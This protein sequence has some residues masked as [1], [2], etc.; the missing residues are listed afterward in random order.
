[1]AVAVMAAMAA[2]FGGGD[3]GGGGDGDDPPNRAPTVSASCDPCRVGP[4]GE[5]R[6]TAQA[7]D[8]DGDSLT[9]AWSAPRG[10]ITGPAD[11]AEAHWR[12]PADTGRVA[13]R[14][15]VSDGRDGTASATVS[16]EVVNAPPEF[17]EP[18]Y[19]FVLRE[20]EAG[21]DRPVALG[22]AVAEDPDG[23]E[24]TYALASGAGDLFA[25]GSGDGTV[26]YLGPGED[27][28]TEPNRYELT[29]RARDVHGA[30]ALAPVFVD[31]VNV[32]EPPVAAADTA[33]TAEDAGVLI[34]VL[35][36]DTDA[37]G[38][39]LRIEAITSPANGTARIAAD[40]GVAYAPEHD[41]HG[42]DRFVYTVA[43]GNGGT[44]EAAV[45]VEVAPVNDAPVAAADTARTA[46]DAEVLIDVLANDTDI[47]GDALRIE[48]ITSPSN[49]TARIAADGG[50]AYAPEHDWHGTDR[51]AYTVADGNGGRAE[52]EVTVEVA[53]VND[54]P[55]AVA[56]TART[57][58]DAEVLI[59]VLAN[60]TDAE[61]DALRIEAITSPANGTARIAASGG[62]EYTPESDWHGTDR[63]A[64]T[65]ADGNG[66]RAEAEVTVKVAPVNDAPVAVS[67]IP[68]QSLEEG[69]ATVTL[70]LTSY[71]EDPDGDELTYYAV[72][73]DPGLAT[74]AVAGSMLTLT[75]VGYGEASVEVTARDPDGFSAAQIFAV[76]ASDRMTR[77][78][79]DETLAAMARAHLASALMTLGGR[80][81]PGAAMSGSML[82]VMGRQVPLNRAAALEAAGRMLESWVVS[83]RL[84]D[85]GL[86]NLV[87]PGGRTEWVFAFGDREEST[88]PAG[89][90]RFWGQGDIQTFAG[91]PSTE[92]EYEGNLRTGWAGIDRALGSRWLVG[93]AVARSTGGGDWRAG[94]SDGRL[95]TSL[96]AVHPYM[97]WSD[98]ASSVWVMAG[99]GRGSAEN[100]RATGRL[101]ESDL[102]LRLGAFE[103]RQHFANWFGL[104]ADAAWARLETGE[105]TETVD[106]RSAV[107]DQQRLGIDLSPSSRLGS[108]ALEPFVEASAR[109]DGGAGQTGSG[110]ELA[111][112]FRASGGLVR[113]DA[114]GRILLLH[115]AEGYEERGLGVTISVGRQV[116]DEG[117]SLS[118]SPH[119]GGPATATGALWREKHV[120]RP[121]HGYGTREAWSLDATARFGLRLPGGRLLNWFGSFNHSRR[122]W[123][124]TV[125][126]GFGLPKNR[127]HAM[128][129][130]GISRV[131]SNLPVHARLV[132]PKPL[133]P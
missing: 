44:A 24:V 99:G 90:W 21:R 48:A 92:L 34:D 123:G 70:G 103:A 85:G 72:S 71:F 75:P 117:L 58:E 76:N 38:D 129:H 132:P 130:S 62:V 131:D 80:A 126:V 41:W 88:R 40:G 133:L 96:T 19:T 104:R 2:D 79:L 107:V 69:G 26:T 12:A 122:D 11:E 95:N 61:G 49:G 4:G 128:R 101:G 54:A 51:F 118:V 77:T 39:A 111:G 16:I 98:G 100:S 120:A 56:D 7:S 31:V 94:S 5:V 27:Y 116:A 108:I 63:F 22:A 83:Q 28:E 73:S 43:D 57:A 97:N 29:V 124:L 42:T 74:V 35:A 25:V 91:E 67:A 10:D 86:R 102:S 8:P 84:R 127:N 89:A 110:F 9:Y 55:V 114:H 60:D 3:F 112:G 87:I 53:P 15:Q 30:E 1:M 37:E 50:V 115:S 105:G 106:S 6:L 64:Y 66:G 36:N 20:N 18:S 65:V 17:D 93:M 119:W 68:A 59:D 23:D 82:K 46:E 33:R 14:V 121:L 13:I 113:V 47:E 81:S 78:V 109:R 32:N 45:T 52:A 125:G